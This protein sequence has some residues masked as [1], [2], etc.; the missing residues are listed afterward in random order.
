MNK[1]DLNF[2]LPLMNAAGMLGFAPDLRLTFHAFPENG[3]AGL[4]AFVTN[5]IS[6]YPR[7]VTAEPGVLRYPGGALIHSGLPNPGFSAVL[8]KYA[9]RWA[10]APLPVIPH[11][12]SEQP[13]ESARMVAE[14]EGLENVA[15]LELGF[16]PNVTDATVLETVAACLGELPLIINLRFDSV[17]SLG[18]EA[19]RLG[20]AALSFAPPAGALPAQAEGQEFSTGRLYGPAFFPQ[21]LSLVLEAVRRGLPVIGGCGIYSQADASAMLAA[22]ALLVQLDTVLWL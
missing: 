2:R 19:I 21:A 20:A 14:L 17:L 8:K 15:A 3:L 12:M 6:R 7:S 18:A 13:L 1:E 22:G 10:G 16:P 9:R 4:G 11:L 5:P